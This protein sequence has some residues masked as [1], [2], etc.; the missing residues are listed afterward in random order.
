[1]A[2][3]SREDQV[4]PPR[5]PNGAEFG[6]PPAR[7]VVVAQI[8]D[9]GRRGFLAGKIVDAVGVVHAR[10]QNAIARDGG[11]IG[12]VD[13]LRLSHRRHR[14][15]VDR[16]HLSRVPDEGVA[17]IHN[18]LHVCIYAGGNG[19]MVTNV[20]EDASNV[21]GSVNTGANVCI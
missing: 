17:W 5:I 4:L 7:V 18:V 12:A 15:D 6:Q 14:T 20:F 13:R 19:P 10:R 3:E 11:E 8:F 9:Q 1:M 16:R 21:R 2:H